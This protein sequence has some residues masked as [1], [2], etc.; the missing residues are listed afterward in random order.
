MVEWHHRYYSPSMLALEK[1]A[2]LVLLSGCGQRITHGSD[3]SLDESDPNLPAGAPGGFPDG[4]RPMGPSPMVPANVDEPIPSMNVDFSKCPE[5]APTP[6]SNCPIYGLYCTYGDSVRVDC[7]KGFGCSSHYQWNAGRECKE[8]PA[9][10]C[11]PNP[12]QGSCLV[13]Y[14]GG[15]DRFGTCAYPDGTM[16]VCEPCP[17]KLCQNGPGWECVAPPTTN[18]C[19]RIIPNVGTPC[20]QQGLTCSYGVPCRDGRGLVICRSGTWFPTTNYAV[21]CDE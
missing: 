2:V 7:R 4:G 8:P 14:P 5:I 20:Q 9:D 16:C 3:S 10:Y 18:G 6:G 19:P 11:P 15:G 1:I 13:R 12:G 17:N 21:G